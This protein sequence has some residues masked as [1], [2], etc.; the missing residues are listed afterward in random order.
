MLSLTIQFIINGSTVLVDNI[1]NKNNR[2]L[3]LVD[4]GQYLV[5]VEEA[6]TRAI[7]Y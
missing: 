6:Q 4:G 7:H 3:F 2:N 5:E 1:T